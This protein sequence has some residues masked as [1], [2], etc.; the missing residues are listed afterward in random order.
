MVGRIAH[1]VSE[2]DVYS[3]EQ[4]DSPS[5]THFYIHFWYHS[6]LVRVFIGEFHMSRHFPD[7]EIHALSSILS[8]IDGNCVP[9]CLPGSSATLCSMVD[10]VFPDGPSRVYG[11]FFTHQ[12][13]VAIFDELA[14]P[15]L[16]PDG[17]TNLVDFLLQRL[18][19]VRSCSWL[20]NHP[21]LA[22]VSIYFRFYRKVLGRG[23]QIFHYFHFS[24]F[25]SGRFLSDLPC[26]TV[27]NNYW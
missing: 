13:L 4:A 21:V 6:R 26:Q 1:H 25:F 14:I 11:H 27:A 20:E 8:L 19:P 24:F 5:G 12:D 16:I 3:L 7:S 17:L 23:S 9:F 2:H 18:R 22:R 10:E 15:F